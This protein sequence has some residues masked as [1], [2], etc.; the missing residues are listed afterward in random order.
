MVRVVN[1]GPFYIVHDKPPFA[2]LH[3]L[4]FERQKYKREEET[5]RHHSISHGVSPTI[6]VF[7]ALNT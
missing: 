5:P 6:F 2:Q 3:I 7:G 1:L 4:Y